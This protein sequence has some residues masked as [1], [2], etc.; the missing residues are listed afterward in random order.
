MSNCEIRVAPDFR[1]S[2]VQ[3]AC[4]DCG[5]RG[6]VRDLNKPD[7]ATTAKRDRSEHECDPW[8]DPPAVGDV[9]E[10]SPG[11]SAGGV[12]TSDLIAFLAARYAEDWSA[13]RD[14]ELMAGLEDSRATR[15][16]DAK[17]AIA[18]LH[19]IDTAYLDSRGDD[20]R[21]VRV[22]EVTCY[23]CGW[24][25]DVEGSGCATLRHLAAI[26]SDHPDYQQEWKP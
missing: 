22:P 21:P 24:A 5:W 10:G 9:P 23:C 8:A 12:L 16:V 17:R 13:A 11:Q 4:S 14:R 20:G 6:P 3:A 2:L 15:D 25:S 7:E 18:A 1:S 26:Y 19:K